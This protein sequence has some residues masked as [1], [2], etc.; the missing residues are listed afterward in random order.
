MVHAHRGF[1]KAA[2]MDYAIAFEIFIETFL[3]GKLSQGY[4]NDLAD[5]LLNRTWRVTDRVSHLLRFA[6]GER[7]Q[8]GPGVYEPW[9]ESVCRPRNAIVHGQVLQVGEEEAENAHQAVYQAIRWIEC[10]LA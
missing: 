4:D 7:L 9:L 3:R 1:F 5:Y 6:A 10:T 2:L 8:D